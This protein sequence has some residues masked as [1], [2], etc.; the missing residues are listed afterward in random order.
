MIGRRTFNSAMLS[1]LAVPSEMV[2]SAQAKG[3]P[4]KP[5]SIITP[6][7]AGVGPDVIARTLAGQLT[8]IWNQQVLV[9]NKPGAGGLIG[10]RAAAQ[11]PADGYSLYLPLSSTFVALPE[12]IHKLPLDLK[13]D[14]APIALIGEQPMV[15]TANAQTGIDNM[16]K[17]VA[18]AKK[19]PGKLTYGANQ[20]S[21]PHL[22]GELLKERAGI[23]LTFI[24]YSNMRQAMQDAVGGAIQVYVESI[25][26][27]S[28]QIKAGTLR[29]L[30]VAS[31]HRLPDHPEL[32]TVREALPG[33]G[34]FEARGWFALM[35]RTGIPQDI[36]HKVGADVQKVLMQ[37]TVMQRFNA[38]GTYV[39]P[40][41]P[42][43]L[44]VFIRSEEA[45]WRPIVRR[46]VHVAG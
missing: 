10:L 28:G 20:G 26:G 39:Q 29:G 45:L 43:Q 24:P 46:V 15:I 7:P 11:A 33:I 27:V 32:P 1:L 16:Q 44:A 2:R 4:V 14:L 37:P 13:R 31:A 22:T 5:V 21:L 6:A 42:T 9:I 30:A 25:A 34:P 38:L 19:Q 41:S 8:Q 23:D 35:A 17:L 36:L 12:R 3:Y 18:Y 40:M